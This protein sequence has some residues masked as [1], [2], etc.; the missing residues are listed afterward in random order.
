[1][2]DHFA[3]HGTSP[4]MCL[5]GAAHGECI[6]PLRLCIEACT[7]IDLKADS[8]RGDFLWQMTMQLQQYAEIR[9][10]WLHVS[11]AGLC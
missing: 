2:P 7:L 6:R 1:M 10:D 8:F 9:H 5:L 3:K 11:G 4:L